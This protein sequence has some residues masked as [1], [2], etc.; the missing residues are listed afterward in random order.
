M[1]VTKQRPQVIV[2]SFLHQ[3]WILYR[4]TMSQKDKRAASFLCTLIL[5]LLLQCFHHCYAQFFLYFE[6]LTSLGRQ[7]N[8]V[9]IVLRFCMHQ[10]LV[11]HSGKAHTCVNTF[12]FFLLPLNVQKKALVMLCVLYICS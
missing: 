2:C 12:V 9:F 5:L 3:Y 10:C 4:F 1:S 7:M 8:K 11:F 6:M